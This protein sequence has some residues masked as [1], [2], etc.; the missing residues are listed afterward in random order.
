MYELLSGIQK[1]HSN[2]IMEHN[3]FYIKEYENVIMKDEC[4]NIVSDRKA[5]GITEC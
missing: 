5:V 1:E 4:C 3:G 2:N